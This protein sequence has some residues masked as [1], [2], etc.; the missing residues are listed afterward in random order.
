MVIYRLIT[1][2]TIEEKVYHRQVTQKGTAHG[3]RNHSCTSF[4]RLTGMRVCLPCQRLGSSQRPRPAAAA[5]AAPA[6]PTQP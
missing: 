4:R 1:S 3:C 2:G 6:P 5:A